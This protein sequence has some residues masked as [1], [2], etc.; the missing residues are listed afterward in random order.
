MNSG[1]R[2]VAVVFVALAVFYVSYWLSFVFVPPEGNDWIS[3]VF[4]L[5]CAIVA[6]RYVWRTLGSDRK[7][8]VPTVLSWSAL[9]GAAGF[10]VG[11]FGP[12]LFA[13]GANQGPLLGIFITG[14]LGFVVGG[15]FGFIRAMVRLRNPGARGD[16]ADAR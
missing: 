7:G 13:P 11:F 2:V 6:G 5:C 4:A 15:I 3:Y 14:P 1:S 8:I 10:A 9:V 16:G 12:M